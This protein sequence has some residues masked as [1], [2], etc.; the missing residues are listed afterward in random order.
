MY[1][2]RIPFTFRMC[3]SVC[4]SKYVEIFRSIDRVKRKIIENAHDPHINAIVCSWISLP[5]IA[6]KDARWAPRIVSMC[7]CVCG[8]CYGK[9]TIWL[10]V[11]EWKL[12]EMCRPKKKKRWNIR[13][14]TSVVLATLWTIHKC[15]ANLQ[16]KQISFKHAH[17]NIVCIRVWSGVSTK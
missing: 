12:V 9:F 5:G 10:V 11:H 4:A 15:H 13:H 7:V 1:L 17:Q 14:T 3:V 8:A 2:L 6:I 16:F